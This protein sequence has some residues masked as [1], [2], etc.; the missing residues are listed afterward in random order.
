[1]N[2]VLSCLVRL[3]YANYVDDK[4]V[5]M[6][7]WANRYPEI[8]HIIP[9]H[10]QLIPKLMFFSY[11]GRRMYGNDMILLTFDQRFVAMWCE[12]FVSIRILLWDC[13][14]IDTYMHTSLFISVCKL[15]ACKCCLCLLLPGC[16]RAMQLSISL[17]CE[18]TKVRHT[19][20]RARTRTQS[21]W[22][23]I[24]IQIQFKIWNF[25]IWILSRLFLHYFFLSMKLNLYEKITLNSS[26]H[27]IGQRNAINLSIFNF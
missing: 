5:H 7:E 10:V 3:L 19:L 16:L 14:P 12:Q 20:A 25:C 23:E 9:V 26:L 22:T 15:L 6:N 1:M 13:L 27:F 24:N 2:I 21:D 8:H 18:T 17:G 4:R 11:D